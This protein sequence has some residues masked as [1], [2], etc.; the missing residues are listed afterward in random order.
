MKTLKIILLA[1]LGVLTV[2]LLHESTHAVTALLV[3]A[4]VDNFTFWAVEI[5]WNEGVI[6][7]PWREAVIQGSAAL[8]NIFCGLIGMLYLSKLKK[9]PLVA[10]G[11][12]LFTFYF[13]VYSLLAGFGYLFFDP[14]FANES[15]VGDWAKIVMLLGG[16]WAVRVPIIVVGTA[17][18]LYTYFYAA[19]N[20]HDFA[21][22]GSEILNSGVMLIRGAQ[23]CVAPY[24]AIGSIFSIAAYFTHPLGMDGFIATLLQYGLGYSGM[25][26]AFFI[27]FFG[28]YDK[29]A[30]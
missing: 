30:N 19:K 4:R 13:T 10:L 15:S 14:I 9:N 7:E 11:A 25:F 23:L 24:V 16:S 22:M 28:L 12:Q 5:N 8:F 1:F 20:A 17:G 18:V 2:Q 21:S 6:I 29:K 27:G 3:G 26:W